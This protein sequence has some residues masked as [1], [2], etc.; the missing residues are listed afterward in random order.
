MDLMLVALAVLCVWVLYFALLVL[1]LG[2]SI[3]RDQ[4]VDVGGA[5]PEFAR[6]PRP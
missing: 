5:E 6:R 2:R 4:H 3:A 1:G